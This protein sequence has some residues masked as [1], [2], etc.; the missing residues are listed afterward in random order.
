[1]SGLQNELE[2]IL[3]NLKLNVPVT[4]GA[5]DPVDENN[6]NRIVNSISLLTQAIQSIK[7]TPT[8]LPAVGS[9][10]IRCPGMSEPWV[11]FAATKKDQWI[12]VHSLYPG[13]F[14]RMAGGYASK[15]KTDSTSVSY[16]DG[17]G[18]SGGGQ[19]DAVQSHY[20]TY[21]EYNCS[22]HIPGT[23]GSDSPNYRRYMY[24]EKKDRRES[25]WNTG[26]RTDET[27]PGNITIEFY[28]FKG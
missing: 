21:D 23:A 1:M 24:D 2:K 25:S 19:N 13:R 15:F 28:V 3:S 9:P 18:G 12:A 4:L 7:D 8:T 5:D 16:D 20:H 11:Q 27:R 10:Y 14:F 17:V 26:R 6:W 22:R